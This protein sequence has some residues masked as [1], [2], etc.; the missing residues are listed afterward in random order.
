MTN[1]A[2]LNTY[3]WNLRYPDASSFQGM[4]LWG[5]GVGG[6]LAAPGTYTVKMTVGDRPPQTQTFVV[7]K[8]P[9]SDATNADLVAQ[10]E[11]LIRIRDQV[12]RANDA[13]RTIRNVKYQLND[14]RG[15]LSGEAASSFGSLATAFAD[16]LSAVEGEIYQVKNRS[17][18]DPLNYPIKLNNQIAALSGFV[19]SGDRRPPPQALEVY[20]MLIPQLDREMARLKRAMDSGLP[21]VN[22]ALKAA[23]QPE[24]VPSTEELGAP[25]PPAAPSGPPVD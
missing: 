12:T 11:F 15:K 20:N 18:Q 24:I 21:K 3:T 6:P 4:V 9:R 22:A 5:G 7:K 13:V 23:G 2:G 8:D 14:R 1:T 10:H 19:A 17:G 25:V 16:S